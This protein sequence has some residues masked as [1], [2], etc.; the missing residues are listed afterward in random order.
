MV[1][2]IRSSPIDRREDPSS[3][4][5]FSYYLFALTYICFYIKNYIFF[6][7][8]TYIYNL[9]YKFIIKLYCIKY[10]YN[11]KLNNINKTIL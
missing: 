4:T 9:I 7:C 1:V 3:F 10:V 5:A 8:R 6:I 2:K 11:N